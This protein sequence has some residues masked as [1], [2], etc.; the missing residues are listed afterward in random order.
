VRAAGRPGQNDGI[1]FLSIPEPLRPTAMRHVLALALVAAAAL[2]GPAHAVDVYKWTDSK[3]VVHYGD[4]PA[5]GAAASTVRVPG[6][7]N[8]NADKAAAEA[9]L[10]A[11]R[12][13]LAEIDDEDAYGGRSGTVQRPVESSCAASWRRYDSAQAC[14]NAHRVAGGKGVTGSGAVYCREV[15]QPGCAR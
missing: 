5:S 4:R 10:D 11:D 2:A 8:S 1:A 15:P 7:G 3:G 6:G 12:E 14:F 13:K 9:S